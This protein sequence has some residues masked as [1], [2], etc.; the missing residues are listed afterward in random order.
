MISG[1]VARH[2]ITVIRA[3]LVDDGRGN[4]RRDWANPTETTIPGWAVDVGNTTADTVNRDGASIEYTVRGPLSADVDGSDRVVLLGNT[5]EVNGGVR[6]QPGPSPL[7][8]H[9]ILLLT[10]WEG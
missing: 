4:E 5:Y 3:P 8:S 10:R 9:T 7:T 2:P 1:A 6:R